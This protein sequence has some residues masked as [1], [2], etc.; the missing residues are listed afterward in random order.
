MLHAMASDRAGQ[1]A[2]AWIALIAGCGPT[3]KPASV[4]PEPEPVAKNAP[5]PLRS[6]G[7]RKVVVGE[8]CP[9]GAG[10]RPAVAPLVMR[11]VGW[12][13]NA[14]D[15]GSVVE[16]G[17]VP[18]F[19]VFGVDGKQAGAF[20]TLGVVEVGMQQAVASGTYVGASPCTYE[21]GA[22]PKG[23]AVAT[24]AEEPR[25]GQLFG[26]CGLAVGEI[27]YPDEPADTV[28]YKVGGV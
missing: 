8:M 23:G 18:R 5:R 2:V 24:R 3:V 1:V 10:G 7:T 26:G 11:S 13:D 9:Q 20:D 22:K 21:V 15:V 14:N 16:R 6:S 17:S 4:P 28:A 25:C 12:T 19:T 27:T